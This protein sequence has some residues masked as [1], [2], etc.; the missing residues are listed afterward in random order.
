MNRDDL[1][2]ALA[3]AYPPPTFA[4]ID[5]GASWRRCDLGTDA[6]VVGDTVQLNWQDDPGT[7]TPAAVADPLGAGLAFDHHCRLFHSVPDEGRIERVL[8][9]AFDPLQPNQ[10]LAATDMIGVPPLSLGGDFV[11]AAPAAAEFTPR[12]LACDDADHLF[13][14]DARSNGVFIFDLEQRRLLRRA[15]VPAGARDI[16]WHDGWLY[17][18]SHA[19]AASLWRFRAA[20]GLRRLPVDLGALEEPGRLT[21]DSLGRL[22]VLDRPHTAGA[23][24]FEAGRPG[25]WR[26]TPHRIVLDAG[27]I[28]FASDI[29]GLEPA[30]AAGS[31]EAPP[32]MLVVARRRNESFVRLDLSVE[33]L[34]PVEPLTARAYDGMGIE[35]TPTGRIAYWTAKGLRHAVASR[36]RYR[37]KARIASFRLDSGQFQTVWGRILLDVCIPN[38]A[39]ISIDAIVSDEDDESAAIALL[40]DGPG[41]P[42]FR[43]TDG[44]E[45][46]W[47]TNTDR[48]ATYEAPAPADRGRYLWVVL[49]LRGTARATPKLRSLRAERHGHDWLRRL[50][51]LYSRDEPMRGFLQRYLAPAA[52]L[53]EDSGILGE[54]RHALL[55]PASVPAEVLPWLASW[56]GLALDERWSEK[57]RRTM[58]R[59]AVTLFRLRGTVEERVAELLGRKRQLADAVLARG[60]AA[61]TELSDEELRDLVTLRRE[62]RRSAS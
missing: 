39:G 52:G 33:P 48:F 1:P 35:A 29:T 10:A 37:S 28:A 9:G 40:T 51:Q 20:G 45:Q 7:E 60:D 59:E 8:W 41:R 6:V 49:W 12:A 34:A 55:K 58:L 31:D 19:A 15:V 56:V 14:L 16:A 32:S 3:Q 18:L 5:G 38:G 62:A 30:V 24:L 21:I 25:R 11:P 42:V 2:A 4:I 43:R 23:T 36:V 22:F 47:S 26:T 44:S 46:P 17:G 13:V 54:T 61:L 27:T 50:P 57:A 53:V